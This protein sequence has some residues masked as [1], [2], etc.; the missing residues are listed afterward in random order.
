MG[1]AYRE[2]DSPYS[3]SEDHRVAARWNGGGAPSEMDPRCDYSGPVPGAGRVRK[4]DE[5]SGSDPVLRGGTQLRRRPSPARQA[6]YDDE[7][8]QL[9]RAAELVVLR[10][11]TTEAPRVAEILAEAGLSNQAFYRHFRSRDDLLIATC[12]RGLALLRDDLA[13]QMGKPR[14]AKGR[15]R[16]WITGV[17]ARGADPE[18]AALEQALLWN[19]NQ[20]PAGKS[21]V[22][23]AGSE[24][25]RQLLLEPLRAGGSVAPERDASAIATLVLT[26]VEDFLAAGQAPR[27][28][29]TEHLVRFCLNAVGIR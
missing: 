19:V 7:V 27:K 14:G 2:S 9:V 12:E 4:G 8:H 26:A 18:R 3:P 5:V 10:R 22:V 15:I 25:L 24:N 6:R 20:V 17:L 28:V 23:A 21:E 1:T 29:D 16:A 13:R 11:G